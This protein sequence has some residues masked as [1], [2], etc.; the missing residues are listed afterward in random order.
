[1]GRPDDDVAGLGVRR[2][3]GGQ[4]VKRQLESLARAQQAEA[5]DDVLPA[6]PSEALMTSGSARGRSGHHA[7]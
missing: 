5:Q 7:G 4:R 3:D 6:T 2:D 1:M